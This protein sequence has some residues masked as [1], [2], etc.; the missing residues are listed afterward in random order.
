LGP[1][2]TA[3]LDE[4][5]TGAN[6]VLEVGCG[7]S[8]LFFAER[9][10]RVYTLD[11]DVDWLGVVL[12]SLDQTQFK[13]LVQVGLFRD[14]AELGAALDSVRRSSMDLVFVDCKE[15]YRRAAIYQS[16]CLPAV[17]GYL[18]VDDSNWPGVRKEIRRLTLVGV[19]RVD[20]EFHEEK[21]HPVT[22]Y[23]VKAHTSF[24][25]RVE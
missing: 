13:H 5:V 1:E 25:Q 8:T 7:A 12:R 15:Y 21:H 6:N 3:Y 19:Y 20:R 22:A 23:I 2:A 11:S 4:L 14:G 18:V 9:A 17:G 16:R 24:L 10:A